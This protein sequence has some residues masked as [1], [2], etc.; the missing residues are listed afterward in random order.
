MIQSEYF[1]LHGKLHPEKNR[2]SNQALR[3]LPLS[4]MEYDWTFLETYLRSVSS[5]QNFTFS[6]VRSVS[7]NVGW[8]AYG[9]VKV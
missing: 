1:L 3:Q 2:P 5:M 8:L 9:I 6:S 7:V 4:T